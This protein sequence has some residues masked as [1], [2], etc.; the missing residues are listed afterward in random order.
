MLGVFWTLGCCV[1]VRL[2]SGWRPVVVRVRTGWVCGNRSPSADVSDYTSIQS[3]PPHP[4]SPCPGWG[5]PYDA[6]AH[7]SVSRPST[8]PTHLSQHTPVRPTDGRIPYFFKWSAKAWEVYCDPQSERGRRHPT[9][10]LAVAHRHV[11]RLTHQVGAHMI[12]QSPPHDLF[13]TTIQHGGQVHEPHPSRNIGNIPNPLHARSIRGGS[14]AG[15][16][17]GAHP[18]PGPAR[19]CA[20]FGAA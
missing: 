10:R 18:G 2:L 20:P 14:L 15:P 4:V 13:R 17:R 3:T 16:G 8:P 9:G 6:R 11:N 12:R 19:W 1:F 5:R 7:S